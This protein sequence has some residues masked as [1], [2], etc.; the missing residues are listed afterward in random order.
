M[1]YRVSD[2][3][4]PMIIH[5]FEP[6]PGRGAATMGLSVASGTIAAV[7]STLAF[8]SGLAAIVATM[9]LTVG[10]ERFL[11]VQLPITL[12]AGSIGVYLFY[13]QHQYED[14]YWRYQEAWNYFAAGLEGASHLRMPRLLQWCTANI[15]LHHIHH[16]SSRI[17][18]YHLQRAYDAIPED[19]AFRLRTQDDRELDHQI[20]R[21]IA[22]A[23]ASRG[24]DVRPDAPFVIDIEAEI[25]RTPAYDY[26]SMGELDIGSGGVEI[27]VNLWSSSEHSLLRRQRD[28]D[29]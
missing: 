19:A 16:V 15:G 5:D 3:G 24:F 20:Q 26:G 22:A 7:G 11:L 13:V 6:E 1:A 4:K 9:W 21:E 28:P 25:D 17:P 18:N 12:L 2:P 27:R 29:P 14:T 10:L 23:L 8:E